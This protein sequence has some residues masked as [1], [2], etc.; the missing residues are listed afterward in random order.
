[1]KNDVGF[2]RQLRRA[3]KILDNSSI[4]ACSLK[5]ATSRGCSSCGDFSSLVLTIIAAAA[6]LI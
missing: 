5:P 2:A 1:M 4:Q 3:F 6:N